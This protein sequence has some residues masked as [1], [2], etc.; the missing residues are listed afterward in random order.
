MAINR[1]TRKATFVYML[2]TFA[3]LGTLGGAGWGVYQALGGTPFD[4]LMNAIR[5]GVVGFAGG[6]VAGII[7]GLLTVI[8]MSI[9]R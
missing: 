1:G 5:L 3:M 6:T 8:Y 7:L 2:E 9:F 4:L